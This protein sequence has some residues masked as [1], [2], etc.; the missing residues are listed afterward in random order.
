MIGGYA[1]KVPI[2]LN[3][4]LYVELMEFRPHWFTIVGFGDT[5]II[6]QGLVLG[7]VIVSLVENDV[8]QILEGQEAAMAKLLSAVNGTRSVELLRFFPGM[9]LT[10]I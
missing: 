4:G 8:P 3:D 9:F 2:A 1:T 6:K 10:F 7:D 5:S